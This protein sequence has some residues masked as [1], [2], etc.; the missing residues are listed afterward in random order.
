M[1]HL[2]S[3]LCGLP[4]LDPASCAA[5]MSSVKHLCDGGPGGWACLHGPGETWPR[6]V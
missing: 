3:P 2:L 6:K 1:P 4:N 5:F